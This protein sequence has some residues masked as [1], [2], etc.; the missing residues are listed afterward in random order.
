MFT[1]LALG[2]LYLLGIGF[3]RPLGGV[4]AA[5]DAVACW[6]RAAAG[7]SARGRAGEHSVPVSPG[8]RTDRAH[9]GEPL[10]CRCPRS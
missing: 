2:A 8:V 6:G 3:F 7:D 9:D 4:A 5:A 10:P 1:W